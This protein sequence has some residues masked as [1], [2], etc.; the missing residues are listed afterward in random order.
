MA[1]ALP[2]IVWHMDEPAGFALCNYFVS[3]M[4]REA[5]VPVVLSGL[6]G[7]EL[8]AGYE[9]HR[10][11]MERERLFDRFA[12]LPSFTRGPFAQR[13]AERLPVPR[14]GA[15]VRQAAIGLAE[16]N[17]GYKFVATHA[18]RLDLYTP[19]LAEI[20]RT[21]RTEA[22]VLPHLDAGAGAVDAVLRADLH[23]FLP[24]DLLRHMDTLSMAFSIEARVPILDHE[25]VELAARMPAEHKIREGELK[26]VLKDAVA[27]LVPESALRRAKQGFNF[28]MHKWMNDSLRPIVDAALHPDVVAKRGL[29]RPEA[30][31]ALV[32]AFRA[33][34]SGSDPMAWWI[35][36]I[37]VWS[38]VVLELWMRLYLDH[39]SADSAPD[40]STEELL[41]AAPEAVL[42]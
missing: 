9:R 29:F 7:D 36:Q 30:V 18:E 32:A 35:P 20:C 27:D 31:E 10:V 22:L 38:L 33:G 3:E 26:A 23:T 4:A 39:P 41:A 15:F 42:S 1:A 5:G 25:L 11:L 17:A 16:R 34:S 40:C 12:R 28:P 19:A 13:L 14:A 21:A 2:R 37:R 6:G 24:N 8:F